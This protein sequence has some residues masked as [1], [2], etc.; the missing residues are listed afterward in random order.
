MSTQSIRR[1]T[2]FGALALAILGGTAATQAA[3]AN[4]RCT[5]TFLEFKGYDPGPLD[6]ATGKKTYAAAAAYKKDSGVTIDDLSA[7]TAP[8]WCE[9]AK[10]DAKFAAL[11]GYSYETKALWA[12]G[13]LGMNYD[14]VLVGDSV[15][16]FMEGLRN[17]KKPGVLN[18][19][20]LHD[21]LVAARILV[22]YSDKAQKDDWFYNGKPGVQQ[23]YELSE[24]R[25]FSMKPGKTYWL[26]MS[27]FIPDGFTVSAVGDQME[28][29]L[30]CL[31][32][33][34]HACR[35]SR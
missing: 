16:N 13:A 6:G 24:T 12:K 1:A 34:F 8:A 7:D 20:D 25:P 23:R 11:V 4:I 33:G 22:K 15:G 5:Q 35:R 3:D 10:A 30:A 9:L 18:Y 32:G 2:A 14:Q 31:A 17:L 28:L 29:R 19:M 26:R 27:A 21:G